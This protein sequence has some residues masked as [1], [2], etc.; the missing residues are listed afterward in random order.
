MDLK[1]CTALLLKPTLSTYLLVR[2]HPYLALVDPSVPGHDV[3]DLQYPVV[4]LVLAHEREAVVIGE[5]VD[6]VGQNVPV[7][8]TDPGDLQ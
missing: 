2:R 6:P 7:L 1:N 8:A 3:L 5:G 4:A